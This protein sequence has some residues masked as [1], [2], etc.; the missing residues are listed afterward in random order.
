MVQ[1]LILE[2][3]YIQRQLYL[4]YNVLLALFARDF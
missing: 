2:E 1:E 3:H 4:I